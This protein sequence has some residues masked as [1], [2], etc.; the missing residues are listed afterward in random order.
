MQISNGFIITFWHY[1]QAQNEFEH[2][3]PI[4]FTTYYS[5]SRLCNTFSANSSGAVQYSVYTEKISLSK[6]KA[7]GAIN[8]DYDYIAVGY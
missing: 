4:T 8:Y 5:L 1:I 6:I 3:I 7:G 2:N